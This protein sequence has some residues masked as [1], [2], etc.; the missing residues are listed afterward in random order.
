MLGYWVIE[1]HLLG[2]DFWFHIRESYF[3]FRLPKNSK[4]DDENRNQCH[5]VQDISKLMYLRVSRSL[6]YIYIERERDIKIYID[7]Q[8][9]RYRFLYIHNSTIWL[10]VCSTPD[11]SKKVWIAYQNQMPLWNGCYV[12]RY[13]EYPPSD[14]GRESLIGWTTRGDAAQSLFGIVRF[15]N[16]MPSTIA[17]LDGRKIFHFWV[18]QAMNNT[19]SLWVL[20]CLLDQFFPSKIK[21]VNQICR[22]WKFRKACTP[23]SKVRDLWV[24]VKSFITFHALH[25]TTLHYIPF[26][27]IT[28]HI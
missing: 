5:N 9:D 19:W 11:A 2:E 18:N 6:I 3:H 4:G 17:H 21:H 7:S 27:Y 1:I 24:P 10:F 12:D 13:H 25:S 16:A 23:E 28:L 22:Q 15:G 8:I 14:C 26:H 20:L